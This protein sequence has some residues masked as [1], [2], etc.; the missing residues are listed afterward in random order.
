M[1]IGQFDL[2]KPTR[3][4]VCNGPLVYKGVGEYHCTECHN[5]DY[6]DY[7]KV[8]LYIEMHHGANTT[9][10]SEGTGVPQS[11]IR[12]LLKEERLEVAANS[13]TFLHCE[14][15]GTEI[16][17]GKYCADC[18]AKKKK[19]EDSMA[20]LNKAATSS[21]RSTHGVSMQGYEKGERRFK[22]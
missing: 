3:C 5:V 16:R 6:D 10:I 15:C 11:R 2:G 22:R 4:S 19:M 18:L 8:R 13:V 1:G 21:K 7:G 9:E 12:Q 17:S 20:A 14:L